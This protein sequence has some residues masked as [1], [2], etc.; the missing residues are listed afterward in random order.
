MSIVDKVIA[1][2]TPPETDA[3]RAEAR[4]KAR[5]A[6]VA[7]SW[8]GMALDQH[9]EIEAGFAAVRS[10]ASATTRRTAEKALAAQLTAHSLAEEVVLYPA[11]ALNG[12]KAHAEAAYVEQSA[13]KVQLAALETLDPMSQDY[14]D[15]LEH[16]R[17]AVAHHVYEEE[18]NWFIEI[19]DKL[20]AAEHARLTKRFEQEY[21]CYTPSPAAA[22]L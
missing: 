11:L 17:G 7:G 10:A 5:A 18:S 19:V 15:K 8:L 20:P 1:A 2:V 21:T 9:L 3:Q 22:L 13:T 6:A 12:E 4:D 14:L 16:I